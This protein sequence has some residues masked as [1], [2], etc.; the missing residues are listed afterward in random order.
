MY[1]EDA[2]GT[3]T[4]GQ[5]HHAI[6]TFLNKSEKTIGVYIQKRE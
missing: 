4:H 2:L 6:P 3:V 1:S 5:I